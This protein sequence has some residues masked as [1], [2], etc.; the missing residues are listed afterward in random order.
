MGFFASTAEEPKKKGSAKQPSVETLHRM[1]C[2]VCPL[3]EEKGL[4][5]PKMEPYGSDEPTIYMLGEAPGE[6]EDKQ[7]RPFV[8]TA[9]KTLRFRMPEW[10]DDEILRWNN[11]VRTRPP[12]NRTPTLVEMECCRP[13]IVRDIEATKPLAIF[14][15]GNVPLQWALAQNGIT[16]WNG[17]RIPINVGKHKCW[18]Y[19]FLHPAYVARSMRFKPDRPDKY[20]SDTDFIFAYDLKHAFED[21]EIGLPEP[22]IHTRERA[23]AGVEFVYGA[24]NGDTNSVLDML[25]YFA[26][27]KIV[28]FDY[29][30]NGLRPYKEGA[31]LLTVGL[32]SRDKHF[33]FALDHKGSEWTVKQR[34]II[35]DAF[36]DFLYDAPCRKVVHNLAFEMEWTAFFY[37][38][39]VLR[40]GKWGD[41]MAQAFI[42]D[43]RMG[44]GKPGCHS[45]EFL[46][47]QHFGLNVKALSKLDRRFLD[48]LPIE[49]VLRYQAIDA[50]YHRLL[51]NEQAAQ[52]KV[53][54]LEEVYETHLARIP[55]MVLTQMKGIPVDQAAVKKFHKQYSEVQKIAEDK[56]AALPEIKKFNAYSKNPF[57][58]SA[59]AD[60]EKVFHAIGIH[61][62]SYDEKVLKE[63]DHPLAGLVIEYRKAHKLL[64]TYI[65]PVLAEGTVAGVAG[66]PH[67]WPDGL[68]HPITTT[69]KTRTWRTSSED[70]NYQN[71][72]KRQTKE[73]RSQIRAPNGY[74]IV[75][76][77]YGQIQARNVA[78]ES[79][80]KALVKA[81]HDRY[82]IHHDWTERIIKRFPKWM[83]QKGGV[84]VV[85]KDK[86][87]WK[88]FRDRTKNEFVFPSFFGAQAKSL[89][90]YL[91]IPENI[92]LSLHEEFWDMFPNIKGWHDRIKHEYNQV[93]YVTGCTGFRR[94]APISPNE[95]INAPIQADE[96]AIVCD[97]MTRLSEINHD[98][99][100][101]NMEIHDDLTFIWPNKKV[102]EY[103]K[104]VIDEMVHVPFKWAHIVPIVVEMSV[105]QDWAN[106]TDWG[107]FASDEYKYDKDKPLVEQAKLDEV[108]KGGW[109]KDGT[110]W[111]NS[112]GLEHHAGN[113]KTRFDEQASEP[114]VKGEATHYDDDEIPF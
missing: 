2:K 11:C 41:S 45:L 108:M 8:G 103:A 17:R 71:W 48:D 28:G 99:L 56:I 35:D 58:P 26:E 98:Y 96:A 34:K 102:E 38:K 76:F 84:K 40:A 64:S 54:G 112:K 3:N 39:N 69:T 51:Y 10:A 33:A 52:L 59:P 85:T 100:Q 23:L 20:G 101:A 42:L 32:S 110:G 31:K 47:I 82:D 106:K 25:D 109:E 104:I 107:V 50:K 9:G 83:D 53:D 81:F 89:A 44:K 91:G 21:V 16:K 79:H 29:E 80:D 86:A 61:L 37:G 6:Q 30:T 111:S 90:G 43:E 66:S 88:W 67:I 114:M 87:L 95:L 27:Q 22:I 36:E 68:A 74:K 46:C 63:V 57:R 1:E 60:L 5:H 19:P 4:K 24:H 13:S 55:T 93:G 94:R 105:G 75:S 7:G 14:G 97:A 78:M 65:E 72:P 92:A 15:F 18:F 113:R 70:F 73:V 49:D 62:D 77:D 12:K